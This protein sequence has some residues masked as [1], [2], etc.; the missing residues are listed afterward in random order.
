MASTEVSQVVDAE[1]RAAA[2]EKAA[3]EQGEQLLVEQRILSNQ[4]RK[5]ALELAQKKSTAFLAQA[6]TEAESYLSS[7]TEKAEEDAAA[8][9]ASAR[10]RQ[11]KA[12]EAAIALLLGK[13]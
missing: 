11:A 8:L 1:A 4:K 9:V 12:V 3:R 7:A 5:E 6:T 10:V 13:A 2:I